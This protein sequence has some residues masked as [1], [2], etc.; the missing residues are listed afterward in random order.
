MET[1]IGLPAAIFYIYGRPSRDLPNIYI[2]CERDQ[3]QRFAYF[4]LAIRVVNMNEGF[5]ILLTI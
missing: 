4:F 2:V 5:I 1:D 3:Q